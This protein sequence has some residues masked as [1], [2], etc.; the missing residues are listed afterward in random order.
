[1]KLSFKKLVVGFCL[2]LLFQ[3]V[4]AAGYSH[5]G[6][7]RLLAGDEPPAGIV[8]EVLAWDRASWSW[9][10]PMIADLR[11]R[12]QARFPGTH[13]AVVSHGGEQFQLTYD[14]IEQQPQ[15][16][17]QLTSL[18]DEGVD[19]HV[20]GAHSQMKGVPET[21][22]IDFVDVSPSGPAQIN[23]YISLGYRHILLN[24]R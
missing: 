20:C 1:M 8:V 10:A 3:G 14:R 7:A 21:D 16:L 4:N 6:V 9:A 18:S 5:P 22:Y 15:V 17:A 23:D 12:V 11:A 13:I 19:I 24:R 2:A